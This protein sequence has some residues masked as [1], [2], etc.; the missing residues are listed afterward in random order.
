MGVGEE[1]TCKTKKTKKSE[2]L[3]RDEMKYMHM[4]QLCGFHTET[5]CEDPLALLAHLCPDILQLFI[6][7]TIHTG[8][9]GARGVKWD[10]YSKKM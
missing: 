7:K 10:A 1:N 6:S 8:R 2:S 5:E 3:W 9:Y 4:Q